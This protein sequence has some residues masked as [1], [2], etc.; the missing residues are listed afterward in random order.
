MTDA[1]DSLDD[2]MARCALRDQRAFAELYRRCS[3]RLLAVARR[4]A[5][6]TPV[7]FL[8]VFKEP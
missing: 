6:N 2:L 8:R 4:V 1:A 7:E 5:P 3:G